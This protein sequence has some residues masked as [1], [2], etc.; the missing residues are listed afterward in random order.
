MKCQGMKNQPT[1]AKSGL[2]AACTRFESSRELRNRRA[3][4]AV[5]GYSDFPRGCPTVTSSAVSRPASHR[6]SRM[7]AGRSEVDSRG[8]CSNVCSMPPARRIPA[9]APFTAS[10]RLVS[11]LHPQ[12]TK[13]SPKG[14]MGSPHAGQGGSCTPTG[15]SGTPKCHRNNVRNCIEL[16]VMRN[17]SLGCTANHALDQLLRTSTYWSHE[18]KKWTNA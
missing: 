13:W 12:Q 17:W 9:I 4:A 18:N 5:R 15:R 11:P 7:S 16:I 10:C 3:L 2:L 8:P 14:S 1:L 6:R